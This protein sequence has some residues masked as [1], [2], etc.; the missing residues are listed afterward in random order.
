M[1]GGKHVTDLFRIRLEK[2]KKCKIK[3]LRCPGSLA[4]HLTSPWSS[5]LSWGY[6]FCACSRQ[7]VY[8]FSSVSKKKTCWLVISYTKG[9]WYANSSLMDWCSIQCVYLLCTQC[10]QGEDEW[11]TEWMWLQPINNGPR[12]ERQNEMKKEE[13]FKCQERCQHFATNFFLDF[14]QS[15]HLKGLQCTPVYIYINLI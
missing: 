4:S 9:V 8:G 13:F 7:V 11:M 2:A 5:V 3:W 14:K 6:S 15:S 10:C 1:E 12:N